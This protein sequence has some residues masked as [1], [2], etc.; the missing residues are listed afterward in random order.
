[1]NIV[2]IFLA[3]VA[4]GIF[5][6]FFKKL[7]SGDYPKRGEDFEATLPSEQIGGVSRPDK[8]FSTPKPPTD[9]FQE[10]IKLGDEAVAKGDMLEAKK[11]L[12]SALIIDDKNIE[13][14]QRL[15]YVYLQS[16]NL[17]DAKETYNTILTLDDR[18]DLAHSALAN[19]F[20]KEG[21][22]EEA[23]VHHKRAIEIDSEYA[24]HYFNYANTLLDT[25]DTT[26][27]KVAYAKAYELDNSLVEAKEM[28]EKLA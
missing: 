10:L 16:N 28:L 2:Q 17:D 13:V 7:F 26:E 6:I 9:R 11:A 27:A 4:I 8:I 19:I 21:N 20:H 23:I 24:P 22:L 12:Q 15:G 18:D 14:L 5:Y 1:M 25:Q 3:L